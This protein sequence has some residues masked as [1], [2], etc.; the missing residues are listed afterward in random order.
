MSKASFVIEGFAAEPKHRVSQSGKRMMDVSVAHT[1]RRKNKQTG[2]W[3]NVTDQNG[4][5]VTLWARATFFGDM[6]DFLA[7]QVRKGVLVRL[8]GEPR[9]NAYTDNGG[10]AKAS[11]D[12]QFASLSIVPMKPRQDAP[13]GGFG[14]GSPQ[15]Q[16]QW[17]QPPVNAP[18]TGAQGFGGG[19]D[20]EQPF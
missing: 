20:Q 13:Q 19:F 9:V 10:Q 3:E 14:G 18:Q 11:I 15:G 12:I 5:E 16:G 2:E 8:E 1:P 7:T 6:A 17:A 4:A